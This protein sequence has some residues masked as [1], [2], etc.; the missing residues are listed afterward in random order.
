MLQGGQRAVGV[1]LD[2]PEPHREQGC[3]LGLSEP[4]VVARHDDLALTG[5]QSA[6]A[7]RDASGLVEVGGAILERWRVDHD[8]QLGAGRAGTD[9]PTLP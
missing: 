7:G 9:E 6:N 2:R 1:S 4:E 5:G 3:G 8:D